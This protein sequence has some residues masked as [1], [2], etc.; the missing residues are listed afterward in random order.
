MNCTYS[1]AALFSFWF[2]RARKQ[3]F[4]SFE[5]T[6]ALFIFFS[7]ILCSIYSWSKP[8]ISKTKRRKQLK[9]P[10]HPN[11]KPDSLAEG[12]CVLV[13]LASGV[14]CV[15]LFLLISGGTCLQTSSHLI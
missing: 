13:G 10:Y 11:K 7:T 6:M 14:A 15:Q 12:T 2:E 3:T 9:K 8:I 1:T 4:V 5:S